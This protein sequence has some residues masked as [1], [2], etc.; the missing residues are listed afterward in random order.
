MALT[1]KERQEGS[2]TI[3]ELK[4]KL[5][6]REGAADLDDTV[7]NLVANGRRAILLEGSQVS[8]LDSEGIRVLV[9]SV[10]TLEKEGGT[11]KL[12]RASPR[13]RRVLEV[14]RLLDAIGLFADEATALKSI[15]E[16]LSERESIRELLS[17]RAALSADKERRRDPRALVDL[18]TQVEILGVGGSILGRAANLSQSGLLIRTENTLEPA[19]EVDIRLNLPPVPPGRPIET[20]GVVVHVK[21]G[22]SMGI[23]FVLL[24]DKGRKALR[25]FIGED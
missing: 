18:L 3:L 22:E 20:K 2:V 13:M 6:L 10:A 19:T 1:I 17:E 12:L 9:R 25:D 8:V 23:R 5:T 16:L 15:R 4:G 11:L 21:P 24:S 14:T 7:Q